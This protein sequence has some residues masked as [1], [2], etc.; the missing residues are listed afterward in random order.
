MKSRFMFTN[1]S[2]CSI[3]AVCFHPEA[4]NLLVGAG[5]KVLVYDATDGNLLDTLKGNASIFN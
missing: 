2:F 5:D 4:L 3:H 1:F